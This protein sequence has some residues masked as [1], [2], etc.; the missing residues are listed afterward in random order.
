MTNNYIFKNVKCKLTGSEQIVLSNDE[1]EQIIVT[2]G[3]VS[4]VSNIEQPALAGNI[5]Y[6]KYFKKYNTESEISNNLFNNIKINPNVSFPFDRIILNLNDQL[7]ICSEYSNNLELTLSYFNI[8]PITN[9]LVKVNFQPQS[10]IEYNPV[11]Y[12]D[13]EEIENQNSEYVIVPE[14]KHTIYFDSVFGWDESESYEIYI[15]KLKTTLIEPTYTLLDSVINFYTEQINIVDDFQWKLKDEEI[16]IDNNHSVVLTPGT[17]TIEFKDI[18]GFKKPDD[19]TITVSERE[20][21]KQ[22]INYTRYKSTVIVNIYPPSLKLNKTTTFYNRWRVIYPNSHYSPWYESREIVD[23]E[24]KD[25][26]VL[27][28]E[29]NNYFEPTNNFI[30]FNVREESPTVFNID[31]QRL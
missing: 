11:W 22:H 8:L 5:D 10:L 12:L 20:I 19:I 31:M 28:I 2:G 25:G 15:N 29:S 1:Y 16:W 30:Q 9:G 3:Y 23:F 26:Y 27:E 17:Y 4:N 14:G 21:Y 6:I 24:F 7:I 18:E 13:D